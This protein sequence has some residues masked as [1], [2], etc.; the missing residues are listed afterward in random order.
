MYQVCMKTIGLFSVMWMGVRSNLSVKI[1]YS[2]IKRVGMLLLL[3]G[4]NYHALTK[5][6]DAS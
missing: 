3:K 1:T 5:I 2:V 4:F 6:K